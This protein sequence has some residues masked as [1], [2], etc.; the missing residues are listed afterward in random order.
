[1]QA[2][3]GWSIDPARVEVLTDVVQGI[4]VAIDRFSKPGEGVV[5]QTP[6]YPPFLNAVRQLE[7]RLVENPLVA[8]PTRW[9]MDLDGLRSI[10]PARVFLLCNPQNPT[11]RVFERRELEAVAE[12]AIAGD[13]LVVAD[14]IHA[15]LVH[16][17]GRHIPFASLAPEVEAR[18]LTLSSASKAFNIPG[19]RC[20]V[21]H[22]GSDAVRRRFLTLPRSLRGGVGALGQAATLAAWSKGGPWLDQVLAYLDGNRRAVAQFAAERWPTVR[23]WLPEATFLTWLDF[24]AFA[25]PGSPGAFFLEHA[26]VALSHG[27]WFG[28]SGRTFA[29]LNFATS[30]ALLGEILERMDAALRAHAGR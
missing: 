20:A 6:V 18:T 13:W 23:T 22:F 28:T 5:L 3:F 19:L 29:R 2:R 25:L 30:R 11:G 24:E 1:M 21:A 7:R 15:D 10:E 9:E 12:A 14:E 27:A 8:G 26:R 4:Y 16:P 17:G